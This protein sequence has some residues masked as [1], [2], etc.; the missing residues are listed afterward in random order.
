VNCAKVFGFRL[1]YV[2][3]SPNYLIILKLKFNELTKC[4]LKSRAVSS[5]TIFEIS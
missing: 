1:N 3:G 2:G 4:A 5:E